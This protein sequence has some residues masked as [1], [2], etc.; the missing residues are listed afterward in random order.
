M[1]KRLVAVA[2]ALALALSAGVAYADKLD[3]VK[4]RGYVQCGVTE[5]VAGFSLPDANNEWV[6]IDVDFCRAVAAAIFN[7]PQAVRFTPTTSTNRWQTLTSGEVDVL[8]RTSTWTMQRDTDLGV[9]FVGTIVYDGQGFLVRKALGVDSVLDLSGASICIE[10]GT[11][12]ELNAADYFAANNMTFTPVT[13]VGQDEVV[14]A[15]EDGR[16]DALTSDSTQLASNRSEFAVPDDFMLLP[17][18]ISKEPLAALVAQGDDRW[19]NVTRWVFFA[20]INAEEL[21]VTQANVDEMLGSDNPEIKRLLGVEGDFGAAI[22]LTKDWA[23]QVIK[24]VGN[25]GETFERNVGPNTEIGLVR[26]LNELWTNGGLQYA[27]PIR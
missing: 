12:T 3:D 21:G 24:H 14:Q 20:Y 19:F 13:F 22:G 26:G 27:P 25:Y 11:T 4:A 16:C 1:K 5:G 6:G 18:I 17:E 15:F 10:Q 8:A 2:A 7:D 23:Y 9:T